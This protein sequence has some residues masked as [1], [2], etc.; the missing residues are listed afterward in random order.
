VCHPVAAW[1]DGAVAFLGLQVGY[2]NTNGEINW[3]GT[4]FR[5]GGGADDTWKYQTTQKLASDV[6]SAPE[7]WKPDLTFV[8]RKVVLNEPPSAIADPYKRIQIERNDIAIDPEPNG[9][10]L[11]DTTLEVRADSAGRLAVGPIELGVALTD[12][13]QIVE[14]EFEPVDPE[15][16][17]SL[18]MEPVRFRWSLDDYNQDRTWTIFTGDPD[19]RPF[20][21][22]RVSVTV[23]GTIFEPGRAW[24]GPWVSTSG[25]GPLLIDVPR[26]GSPGVVARSIPEERIRLL[27]ELQT[28][29]AAVPVTE[30]GDGEKKSGTSSTKDEPKAGSDDRGTPE[31]TYLN[32]QL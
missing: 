31:R 7:G 10:L 21:R 6:Q 18:E 5:D 15:S 9:I 17:N 30:H 12:D 19:F 26:P 13:T 14:A 4:S 8:K 16:G 2:P 28:K 25:N 22:Y 27:R 24:V 20:Y 32:Y 11:N 29:D 3:E 23:K 1:G